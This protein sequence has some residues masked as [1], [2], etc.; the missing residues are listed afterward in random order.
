MRPNEGRLTADRMLGR[1]LDK[2]ERIPMEA[3]RQRIIERL[4]QTSWLSHERE[5]LYARLKDAEAASA[6]EL[7]WGRFENSHNIERV[8]LKDVEELYRLTG[9]Q[10]LES[11]SEAAQSA[12]RAALSAHLPM[13]APLEQLLADIV[14][15]WKEGKQLIRGC[16]LGEVET[17]ATCFRVLIALRVRDEAGSLETDVRTFSRKATGDSKFIERHR[18][19]IAAMLRQLG[20][21]PGYLD[22]EEALQAKGITRFPHPCLISGSLTH[23]GV[24]LP[25]DPYFGAA[26]EVVPRLALG[27]QPSWMMTI[28]NLASFNRQV[29]E[30]RQD[31]LIV[32]TGGF[33]SNL[34]L[35]AILHLAGQGDFPIYHW[36]DIDVG[37]VRIAYRIERALLEIDRKLSLHLMTPDIAR[38]H[39]A[40]TR[41]VKVFDE[42]DAR[43]AT[44]ALCKFLASAKARTMEQ[45]ELDPC[46]PFQERVQR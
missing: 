12:L 18:G 25:A 28:E 26:P 9:R 24:P 10:P 35:R 27:R 17:L 14:A 46:Q 2:A 20:E 1:L 43:S 23:D 29:R 19:P 40:A 8:I 38:A 30:C 34:T 45:E 41:P 36:G 11:K 21:V 15:S 7:E 39:G 44:F 33:P 6:V 16:G 42:P 31:G 13:Q 4:P 32:Y 5:E 22:P 3:R 37:G